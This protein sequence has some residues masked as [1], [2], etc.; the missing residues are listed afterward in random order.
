[1]HRVENI[2]W[3][4]LIW[5]LFSWAQVVSPPNT[6]ARMAVAVSHAY[7]YGPPELTPDNRIVKQHSYD[8]LP[9]TD[10]I[11]L[12]G[13]CAGLEP[14]LLMDKCSNCEPDSK[15]VQLPRFVGSQ[16]SAI[17]GGTARV[18]SV[19]PPAKDKET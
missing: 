5:P 2:A 15:V 19:A 14:F 12:C 11:P 10:L 4:A 1:M 8:P 17:A 9:V 18:E 6:R 13:G 16:P 7:R 3:A